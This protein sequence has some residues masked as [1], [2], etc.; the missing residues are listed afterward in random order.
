MRCVVL[1]AIL[2]PALLVAACTPLANTPTSI[3][4]Q[5]SLTP[6][7]TPTPEWG[8][9]FAALHP[10]AVEMLGASRP[11]R[12]YSVRPD[13]SR[14]T[15]LTEEMERITGLTA[16]PDGHYLLFAA[17]RQDTCPGDGGVGFFDLSHLYMLDV[18]SREIFTLTNGTTTE[19]WPVATWSPDGQQIAFVSSEVNAPCSPS[20]PCYQ[21]GCTPIV[22]E[23]RTHL[24]VMNRDGT[25][26][27]KLTFQEGRTE[28]VAWS[29]TGEQILFTQHG[30]LWVVK[31]DG[32]DLLKVADALIDHR[33]RSFAT[34]PVWSPDGRQIA[35]VA[36]GIGPENHPDIFIINA[37]GSGLFNLTNH[38]SEDYQPAWSPDGH[39]L[40][41]VTTRHGYQS[42]YT[43]GIDGND[44]TQ[45][46]SSA[47]EGAY[48]PTW[49]PD[50]SRIAF[51]V[52]SPAVWKE[53]LFLADLTSGLSYRL[54]QEFVG[55]HPAWIVIPSR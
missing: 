43:I 48:H 29:P 41:F 44:I 22:T 5:P 4:E 31:P 18:S 1:L 54:S 3:L 35:F 6:T 7:P 47:S 8:I 25:G 16:S 34:R 13:A 23:Y 20:P 2:G 37:D 36:S 50:G 10:E 52:G 14:L 38:S 24:Y 53:Q 17:I 27:R 39:H 55:D 45:V 46:F 49:S 51:V 30:A 28:A 40:A 21:E 9:A 15:V 42:I 33:G 26:K 19:E 12:L 32:S 11:M